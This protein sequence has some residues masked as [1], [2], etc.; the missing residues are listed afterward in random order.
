M[1]IVWSTFASET[2]RDIYLYYK[3]VAGEKIAKRIKNDIFIATR[4]LKN[5]P[6]SGQVENSL[7]RMNEGHRYLVNGNFKVIYKEVIEGILITDVFD[8]RQNPEKMNNPERKTD[9]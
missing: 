7:I 8:T 9:R 2:L 1:K 4:Q 3:K 5:H 6:E